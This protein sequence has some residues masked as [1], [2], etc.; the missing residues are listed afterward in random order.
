MGKLLI[1]AS[2][3][4]RDFRRLNGESILA[5]LPFDTLIFVDRSRAHHFED[6]EDPRVTVQIVCWSDQGDILRMARE[7]HARHG[8]L[9]VATLDE[10]TVAFAAL[11]RAELDVPGLKPDEV[12]RFRDKI[13]MKEVLRKA[14][15]RVP[16][17]TSCTDRVATEVLLRQHGRIVLKPVNGQGSRGVSIV[18][19]QMDL[20]YWFSE[21]RHPE[22]Y[23]A[24][25]FIDGVLYHLN[26][27]V[28]DGASLLTSSAPYLPG[29]AN[30]DFSRGTPFVTSILSNQALAGRMKGFSAEVIGALGLR[31]GV[32]HLECFLTPQNEIVFCEIAVRPG[33]GGIVWMIEAQHDVHYGRS[34]LLLEAGFG[35]SIRIGEPKSSIA[36][37]IGF[38]SDRQGTI[39]RIADS[40]AFSDPWIYLAQIYHPPGNFVAP[41]AHCTDYLGLIIFS[42]KDE[43]EFHSRR[44]EIVK[45]FYAEFELSA[46]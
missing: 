41:S 24:E 46:A 13:A 27:L 37:L 35:A 18:S 19:N 8:L 4:C 44:E 12:Q 45:R 5:D 3:E 39:K 32:T 22:L 26:A 17:F 30:I 33:G 23:E 16:Q 15:V 6:L 28:C 40:R 21:T 9:G 2:G 1:L 43:Q 11:L 38:R 36:G 10:R 14:G 20:N 7:A 25:E 29:Q 34:T 31:N 42:S